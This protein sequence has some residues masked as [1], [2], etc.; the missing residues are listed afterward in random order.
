M[1]FLVPRGLVARGNSGAAASLST[2]ARLDSA[3]QGPV[4]FCR[5]NFMPLYSGGCG[6]R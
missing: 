5:T 6:W 3:A 4:P 2:S 1:A